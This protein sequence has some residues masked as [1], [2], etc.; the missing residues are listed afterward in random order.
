MVS[1]SSLGLRGSYAE[2]VAQF[3]TWTKNKTLQDTEHQLS[4][5][6]FP[7]IFKYK[8][9]IRPGLH[10]CFGTIVYNL[11]DSTKSLEVNVSCHAVKIK[12]NF[13]FYGDTLF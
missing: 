12:Y 3:V 8:N 10:L 6:T 9:R 7:F 5:A 4:I 11:S 13:L 1:Y 2:S